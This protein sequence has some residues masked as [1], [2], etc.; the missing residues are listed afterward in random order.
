MLILNSCFQPSL[1]ISQA[2]CITLACYLKEELDPY[3]TQE[4]LT[5]EQWFENVKPVSW[6]NLPHYVWGVINDKIT[7]EVPPYMV[8]SLPLRLSMFVSH[9]DWV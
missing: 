7:A 4:R 1:D 5:R 2:R 6:A 8:L 9:A 3:A